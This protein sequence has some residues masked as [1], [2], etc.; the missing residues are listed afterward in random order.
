MFDYCLH[1]DLVSKLIFNILNDHQ[2]V[3]ENKNM[4]FKDYFRYTSEK[5]VKSSFFFQQGTENYS[6]YL[7]QELTSFIT[8]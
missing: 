2:L 3:H 4:L 1:S 5:E 8:L 7:H 6:S